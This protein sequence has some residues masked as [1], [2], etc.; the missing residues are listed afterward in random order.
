MTLELTIIN[1][2]GK[3]LHRAGAAEEVI[4][5]ARHAFEDGDVI[6]LASTELPCHLEVT[7]DAAMPPARIFLTESPLHFSVPSG[8][9]RKAYPP[10]AFSGDLQR[11]SCRC[12]RADELQSRRNLALNPFDDHG[13]P[14]AFPHA[15]AN[16]ETRGEAV[17]AAR[18]AIDGE[19]ANIDHGF[20][21]F[22]SWGINRDPE[23]SL[24][25][26]FGREVL[27]DEIAFY[28]RADF[29]H[30][31]WWEEVSVTF[32]TGMTRR[33]QTAKSN[34]RQA[35]A[36]PETRLSWLRL[37]SLVKADDPSPFPALTQLEVMGRDG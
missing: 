36:L 5:V 6:A 27:V 2:H 29:P 8:A 19:K 34:A 22:T 18:N 24:T 20:W 32:S 3:T 4:L 16:V 9:R 23:A 25:V 31:A 37:H 1:R 14:R 12:L 33:F 15:F 11:L 17:F 28:L 30:D 13:T 26:D 21:P 10:Q 7:L 35:F